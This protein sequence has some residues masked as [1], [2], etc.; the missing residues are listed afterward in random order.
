MLP[1]TDYATRWLPL[2]NFDDVSCVSDAMELR[3]P[4][5]FPC[6]CSNNARQ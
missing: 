6:A 4:Y 3:G 1:P 2:A 5:F